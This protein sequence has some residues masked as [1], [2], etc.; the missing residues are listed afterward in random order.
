MEHAPQTSPLFEIR[1][2]PGL[3]TNGCAVGKSIANLSYV[4][5]SECVQYRLRR[6][7]NCRNWAAIMK[8]CDLMLRAVL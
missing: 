4:V 3:K 2:S 7:P 5:C 6:K 8:D 1:L